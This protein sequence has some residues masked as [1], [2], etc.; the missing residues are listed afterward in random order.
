MIVLA[1]IEDV[2]VRI[3]IDTGADINLVSSQF[4]SHNKINWRKKFYSKESVV[5]L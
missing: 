3:L 4:V 1:K 2:P 5:K